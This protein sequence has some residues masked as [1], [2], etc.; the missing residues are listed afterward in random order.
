MFTL[1]LN[2]SK[3]TMGMAFLAEETLVGP[4]SV[5]GTGLMLTF[6]AFH[7]YGFGSVP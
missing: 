7:P 4:N 1:S 3:L 5:N 6:K 2:Q